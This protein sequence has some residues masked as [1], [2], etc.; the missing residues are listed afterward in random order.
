MW[1]D[2][3]ICWQTLLSE[4]APNCPYRDSCNNNI[5]VNIVL[6]LFRWKS[7]S[8]FLVMSVDVTYDRG[9]QACN[10][11]ISRLVPRHG[12]S[13]TLLLETVF[14]KASCMIDHSNTV[15][16]L[17][18]PWNDSLGRRRV[19]GGLRMTAG[20]RHVQRLQRR[21]SEGRNITE[22]FESITFRSTVGYWFC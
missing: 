12:E 21:D 15:D 20:R 18:L 7:K 4:E 1:L 8:N 6:I 14:S 5:T 9:N 19:M 16:R 11:S 13:N 2:L 17:A 22:T 3:V 10:E